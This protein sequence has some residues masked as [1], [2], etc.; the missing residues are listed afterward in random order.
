MLGGSPAH[1]L[2]GEVHLKPVLS[3]IGASCPTPALYLL[4]SEWETEPGARGVAPSR[5]SGAGPPAELTGAESPTSR[6]ATRRDPWSD[7]DR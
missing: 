6:D 1:T 4:D 5:S 7:D 3:E 2:A